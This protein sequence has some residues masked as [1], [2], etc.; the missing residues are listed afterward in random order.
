VA[1]GLSERWAVGALDTLALLAGILALWVD[2]LA[3]MPGLVVAGTF[4]LGLTFFGVFLARVEV[5]AP[6]GPVRQ[7]SLEEN[8]K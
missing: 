5:Y 4:A 3:L 8:V 7:K 1:L 6:P 2:G